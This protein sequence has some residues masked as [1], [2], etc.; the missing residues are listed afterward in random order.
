MAGVSANIDLR[1]NA[2]LVGGAHGAGSVAQI[3]AAIEKQMNFS[4]GTAAVAQAN[5]LYFE[6]L[7][8][9]ASGNQNLDVAGV[10]VDPLGATITAAEIVAVYVGAATANVNDVVLTRPASNGLPL[11]TTAGA[12]INIGP[13]DFSLRTYRN[14][15]TVTPSTGDLINLANSGAGTSVTFDVLLL[16]RTVAA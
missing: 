8:I 16:G 4:A 14:G 6:T 13:G 1:I 12:G 9:A 3:L 10:L 5:L 2:K 7:T 11:F 15:I